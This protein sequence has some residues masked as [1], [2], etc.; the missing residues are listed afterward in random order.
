MVKF[1]KIEMN[2]S[3]LFILNFIS[4]FPLPSLSSQWKAS[5]PFL[6]EVLVSCSSVGHGKK[7]KTTLTCFYYKEGGKKKN[8]QRKRKKSW[9][10]N[11]TVSNREW[12]LGNKE[13][14]RP[15]EKNLPL[16]TEGEDGKPFKATNR[17]FQSTY[18]QCKRR[19]SSSRR[20]IENQNNRTNSPT[21][22]WKC[23]GQLFHKVEDARRAVTS[24]FALLGQAPF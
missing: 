8:P 21:C 6:S 13:L 5:G 24:H 15:G 2:S 20:L 23:W 18:L 12:E 16:T 9:S 1:K 19:P 17:S 7:K 4:K 22:L 11:K 14:E 10:R 3:F